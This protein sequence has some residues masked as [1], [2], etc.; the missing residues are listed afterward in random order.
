[1]YVS[2]ISLSISFWLKSR[3]F[4]FCCACSSNKHGCETLSMVRNVTITIVL[5]AHEW[6]RCTLHKF[7]FYFVKTFQVNFHNSYINLHSC[8][9]WIRD[10]LSLYLLP[11]LLTDFLMKTILRW[12]SVVSLIYLNTKHFLKIVFGYFS[13]F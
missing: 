2:H 4:P 7:N 6:Q 12:N 3:Q 9:Q 5:Y 10:F 8:Q 1:M 11:H 13:F